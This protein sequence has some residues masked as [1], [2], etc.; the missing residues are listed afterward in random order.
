ME[1]PVLLILPVVVAVLIVVVSAVRRRRHPAASG[2]S[3][4]PRHRGQ[5]ETA[6]VQIA[7]P[8]PALGRRPTRSGR[9]R[10]ADSARS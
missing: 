6:A 4:E 9:E 8:R 5:A 1:L 2:T 3:S 7:R 10:R